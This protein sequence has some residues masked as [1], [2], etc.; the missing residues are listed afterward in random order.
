M[1]LT[2]NDGGLLVF[3]HLSVTA[4]MNEHEFLNGQILAHMHRKK[5]EVVNIRLFLFINEHK[6][7]GINECIRT[8]IIQTLSNIFFYIFIC[9][10]MLSLL[11]EYNENNRYSEHKN[12]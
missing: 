11:K 1:N 3:V 7:M 12:T 4:K 9:L 2:K 8:N 5:N 6:R 10:S